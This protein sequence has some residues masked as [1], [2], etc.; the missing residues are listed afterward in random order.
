MQ[1]IQSIVLIFRFEGNRCASMLPEVMTPLLAAAQQP[2]EGGKNEEAGRM[3]DFALQQIPVVMNCVGSGM[4][5]FL[6]ELLALVNS[7]W[8]EPSMQ[9][10]AL[11]ILEETARGINHGLKPHI[12]KLLPMLLGILNKVRHDSAHTF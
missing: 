9:H 11:S 12:K 6:P 4:A 8:V 7:C 1:A 3:R 2:S 10:H 5:A